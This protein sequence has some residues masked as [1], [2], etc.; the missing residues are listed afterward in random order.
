MKFSKIKELILGPRKRKQVNKKLTS[1]TYNKYFSSIPIKEISN[2]LK[3]ENIII[4]QED[5]R[6]WSG[7]LVG[8]DSNDTF[9]IGDISS[10]KD[11]DSYI[12]YK[13]ALLSMSWYKMSSGRYEIVV[14]VT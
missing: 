3:S 8:N 7:F 5:N 13:N 1:F 4:L 11:D 6:E 14:Y 9:T 2:I 12:P 10:K